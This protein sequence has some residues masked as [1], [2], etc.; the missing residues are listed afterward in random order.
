MKKYILG[1]VIIVITL[2]LSTAILIHNYNKIKENKVNK[3]SKKIECTE[4]IENKNGEFLNIENQ[5]DEKEN[6][7]ALVKYN[8]KIYRRTNYVSYIHT[9]GTPDGIIKNTTV[10][11]KLPEKD[12]ESNLSKEYKM[13]KGIDGKYIIIFEDKFRIFKE[14]NLSD[15]ELFESLQYVIATVIEVTEERLLIKPLEF[16]YNISNNLTVDKIKPIA[17][18]LDEFKK[19]DKIELIKL[20]NKKIKVYY[21]GKMEKEEPEKSTPSEIENIYKIKRFLNF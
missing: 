11:G 15:D 7:K 8:G 14:T 4:K 5:K 13:Q 9:C 3:E 21:S 12:F 19:E 18:K 10:K 6:E 1:I 2:I 16:K 20:K 17:V